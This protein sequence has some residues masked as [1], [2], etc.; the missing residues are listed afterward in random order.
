MRTSRIGISTVI[1]YRFCEALRIFFGHI[2]AIPILT[3][4]FRD[5]AI[6]KTL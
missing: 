5:I 4:H 6:A 1:T 3:E 2:R